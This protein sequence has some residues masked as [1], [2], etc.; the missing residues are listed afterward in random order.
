MFG[1]CTLLGGILIAANNPDAGT[2]VGLSAGKSAA[3]EIPQG[4][5]GFESH[6]KP[7]F[8]AHCIECHGPDK[9]KGKITVHSLD[10]DLAAGQELDRWEHIL[11]AL[12][13]VDMP[14]EEEDQPSA[15]ERAA[16]VKW[17]ESGLRD[18][19][20]EQSKVA[21][22]TTTRRL[23]NFEYQNTMRDLLGIDLELAEHL[24]ADPDKPYHFNNSAKFMLIGPDQLLRYKE[25]ARRAM[26][27]A[28]VDPEKP[29]VHKTSAKWD[30]VKPAKGGL[31]QAEIAVYQGPGVGQRTVGLKSWPATGEF[32]IRFKAA[33][34]LPKG[35]EEVP[36]RLVMGTSLRGDSGSGVYHPVGTVHLT[37]SP[38]DIQEYEFRGRIENIPVQPSSTNKRG[39][40]PPSIT[41]TAQNLFDNGELNDHRKSGFD[42]SW[43]S[44]APR[45]VLESLEFEAPVFDAWPPEHHTRILFDSPL[46]K[47][48]PSKYAYEVIERF[49]ERAFRRPVAKDEVD[50]FHAI[51][52]IY[53]A[54]FDS[55]EET[56]RETLAMVLISPQFLYHTVISGSGTT[57]QYELASR[58]SYFLWGSM[59][60]KELFDLAAKGKL[61]DS[62]VLE[63][64][65]QRL[66]AD[67]RSADFV[68]NF[69]TQWLSISKLKTVNINRDLFPR[70]LYT[71][72]IGE[73]RGQ[74]RLFRPTIRDDMEQE[75][76][77]FIAELIKRNASVMNIVD[78][79]FAYLNERLAVHYGV[80]GVKGQ[81]LR[82]VSIKPEHR[83]GGLLTHGSVLIG[84][85][86]G[87]APHTI[88]RA[89]WLREAILGDE[90]KPPP[91][92]VPALA[93]SAGDSADES[94]S[95]KDLLALHRTKESC[96]DC[97]VRLDPWGI[98]FERYSAIGKYQPLVPKDGTRVRGFNH[99]EDK[100]L[101]GYEKYLE[102]IFKVEV[103]ASSRVPHGP[104][105]D[106]MKDLKRYL[107]KNRKDEV[108]ENVIRR[109][110]TYGI[111]R[112][113][114]YRDRFAVEELLEQAGANDYKLKDMI[115][116][117]CQSG[118]FT[119]IKTK[120]K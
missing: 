109:L 101:D 2:A 15:D 84:N 90:V 38:D 99:K 3:M 6:I 40:Q 18:Y 17:I 62:A 41:I 63:A 114:T 4:E 104:K 39:V 27:S 37:N 79:D 47:S 23:T 21:T 53:N 12:E 48:N 26:A 105:V 32:K 115:V 85:S 57:K 16:V 72:H 19:V 25:S 30:A 66:L 106:G 59:P 44:E 43:A 61:A 87:S 92:E 96:A 73:R 98:P 118:T 52:K 70:F 13:Q 55:F 51:Y 77:G 22:E 76:I 97:H 56:M 68:K 116:S 81:G 82:P 10:G 34:K 5:V 42:A 50:H 75:T 83:L 113:L 14:P 45:V 117:I 1:S 94:S 110:M 49:M 46:R 80:E 69:S 54:D 95:I 8:K 103:D 31:T 111:A 67:E 89:V 29:K 24:S 7:F 71:V 108:A 78:S 91:A 64:Q 88:Y 107:L 74:E 28:I 119:G 112:E 36:L 9:S 58:L 60:D 35:F 11:D 20:K 65:T 93:D 33:G 120:E 100:N 102:T 86:T